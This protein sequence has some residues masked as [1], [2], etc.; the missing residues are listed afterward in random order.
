M[1]PERE[2]LMV[3][4]IVVGRYD[5]SWSVAVARGDKLPLKYS[6]LSNDCHWEC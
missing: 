5:L 4:S 3:L 2:N 6:L 1:S